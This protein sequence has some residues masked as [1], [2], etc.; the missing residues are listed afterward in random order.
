MIKSLYDIQAKQNNQVRVLDIWL[1]ET[2]NHG[3]SAIWNES[4]MKDNYSELCK[5]QIHTLSRNPKGLT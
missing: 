1:L 2:P 3:D 4:V 5:F